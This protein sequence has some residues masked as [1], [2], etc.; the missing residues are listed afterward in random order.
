VNGVGAKATV[1]AKVPAKVSAKALAKA[2][3]VL[4]A[5]RKAPPA[6]EAASVIPENI[7]AK[8][9]K[10]KKVE[11]PAKPENQ[12]SKNPAAGVKTN[13]TKEELVHY[14]QLLIEKRHEILGDVGTMESEAFKQ[15]SNLSNMPS[16]MAD[17][18]TDNFEQ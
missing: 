10:T 3:Q 8:I 13:L 1:S 6:A 4:A 16:H 5:Q 7:P 9:E 11:K 15:G 14:R 2:P 17:V 18:G 12:K